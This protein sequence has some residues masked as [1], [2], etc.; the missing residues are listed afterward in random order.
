M[1]EYCT[2]RALATCEPDRRC[3]SRPAYRSARASSAQLARSDFDRGSGNPACRRCEAFVR[4]LRR[5]PRGK[6]GRPRLQRVRSAAVTARPRRRSRPP[7]GVWRSAT[8]PATASRSL[9]APA[10]GPPDQAACRR[11]ERESWR[12]PR[13][14]PL[15]AVIARV[16]G[17]RNSTNRSLPLGHGRNIPSCLG[18]LQRRTIEES[19]NASH[20]AR[21][22]RSCAEKGGVQ[23]TPSGGFAGGSRRPS[24]IDAPTIITRSRIK[25]TSANRCQ[26]GRALGSDA[27]S[28]DILLHPIAGE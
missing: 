10:V 3:E 1:R 16:V 25:T 14:E 18:Y 22:G 19:T 20:D 15:Q 13:V 6:R 23:R 8:P 28:I 2:D 17:F 11:P 26:R 12:P 9:R 4:L 21:A 5:R 27:D 24:T 7:V